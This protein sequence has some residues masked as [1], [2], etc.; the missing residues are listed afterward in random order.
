MS[1]H[2][3]FWLFGGGGPSIIR[4]AHLASQL[5]SHLYQ[6]QIWKQSDKDILSYHENDEVSA[7]MDAAAL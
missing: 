2:V 1:K 6:Y 3:H 7:D 5:Y 4:L